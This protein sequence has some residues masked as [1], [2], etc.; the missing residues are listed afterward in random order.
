MAFSPRGVAALSNPSMLAA[1]FMMMDPW[2]GWFLGTSGN[3]LLKKG[4][5]PLARRL[6]APPFSPTF[7][8]PNQ[9]VRTPMRP[10]QIS[11]ATEAISKVLF[12]MEVKI[13]VSCRKTRRTAPTTREIRK[14][15]IQM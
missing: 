11:T 10:I 2:T 6:T 9:R 3:S 1:K 4:L 12:T 7:I 5:T 13:S 8:S 15:A 14:N